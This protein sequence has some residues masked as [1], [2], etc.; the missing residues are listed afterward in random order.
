MEKTDIKS[1]N[2]EELQEFIKETGEKAFRAKQIYQ[3]MHE[4]L[5]EGFDEMTN[6]SGVLREKLKQTCIYTCLEPVEVLTSKLDGTQKYLFR[7]YPYQEEWIMAD[8]GEKI[9]YDRLPAGT[10]TFQVKTI[11]QDQSEGDVSTL[12]VV[13]APHWSETL[14]FRLLVAAGLISIV[15]IYLHR[16]RLK[17][18]RIQ[19]ELRL[20]HEL[21]TVN[22]E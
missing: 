15:L 3:W 7:L 1:L 20:E 16:V 12:K 4:K 10:Y 11:F 9:S 5:A 8:E 22:M 18:K 17:Q 6:L 21:F 2:Y 13:I 14:W 19:Y